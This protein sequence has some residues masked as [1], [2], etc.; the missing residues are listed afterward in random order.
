MKSIST[1][2]VLVGVIFLTS[3]GKVEKHEIEI[4]N[5]EQR[6]L[7]EGSVVSGMIWNQ[8]PASGRATQG[9]PIT[10]DSH[11]SVY[12]SIAILVDENGCKQI[13]PLDFISDLK[14]K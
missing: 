8:P 12:Q 7:V 10:Q 9:E 2:L 4:A 11:I 3:C 6:P 5:V 1:I 13:I 14:I